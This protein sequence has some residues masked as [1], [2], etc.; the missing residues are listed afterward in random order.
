ML[1]VIIEKNMKLKFIII[2][3]VFANGISLFAQKDK[4]SISE[5]DSLNGVYIPKSIDECII[6]LNKTLPD[7]TRRKFSK[8][9]EEEAVSSSH[10]GLGMWL[11]NKWGLWAGTRLTVY[12]NKLGIFH[13][14]DMSGIILTSYHRS[15]NNIEIKLDAQVKYYQDYWE[16]VKREEAE[17]EN[18]T[19]NK[20]IV[21]LNWLKAKGIEIN[22]LPNVDPSEIIYTCDSTLLLKKVIGD[23]LKLWTTGGEIYLD[24]IRIQDFIMSKE[25]GYTSYISGVN[26]QG[27]IAY[28]YLKPNTFLIRND[29]LFE[30]ETFYKISSDSIT[31]LFS[32]IIESENDTIKMLSVKKII[33]EN[34]YEAFKLI[35]HPAIFING[36][37]NGNV[38]GDIIELTSIWKI[39]GKKYYQILIKNTSGKYKT[40]Y[41]YRFDQNYKFIDYDGC[42]SEEIK[43]LT[44]ENRIENNR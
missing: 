15:L 7:S 11:R 31:S 9:K 20:A 44:N 41:S 23:T 37:Y 25:F 4:V 35:F 14:D 43:K 17:K 21:Y 22:R 3:L 10:F 28:T 38:K 18:Q 19:K 8:M 24:S 33:D 13:P 40:E 27:N 42:N 36:I 5:T 1:L 6:S 39:E 29:S 34:T 2:V 32:Q 12:F 26:Y 16:Q 30:K